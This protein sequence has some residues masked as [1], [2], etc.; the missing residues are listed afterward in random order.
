MS[1]ILNRENLVQSHVS[2]MNFCT[3]LPGTNVILLGKLTRFWHIIILP[4]NEGSGE[5]AQMHILAI[6]FTARMHT[7]SMDVDEHPDNNSTYIPTR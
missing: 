1:Y 5:P 7:Q 2:L 6:A 3:D 4:C